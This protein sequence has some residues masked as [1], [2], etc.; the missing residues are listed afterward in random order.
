MLSRK[1]AYFLFTLGLILIIAGSFSSFLNGLKSDREMV[2]RRMDDVS[3]AYEAFNTNVSFFGDYREDFHDSI[4]ENLYYET[5]YNSDTLVK[6]EFVK[7]EKMVDEITENV[8]ELEPLCRDV[9]YPNGSINSMCMNYPSIY[10]QVMNYFL[11]DVE[12]YNEI[13]KQ[14]NAYQNSINSNYYV[15]EY[16]TTKNYIDYNG[17]QVFEGKEE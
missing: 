3:G 7:Y 15:K 4:L 14:Y 5:M 17:D 8:K 9:Y 2:M 16:S 6:N 1:L 11:I 13:V 10:E 12:E